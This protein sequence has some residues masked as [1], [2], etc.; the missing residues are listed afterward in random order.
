MGLTAIE[1]IATISLNLL[2]CART[3]H[4]LPCNTT[5]M[6][7]CTGNNEICK[8]NK[9]ECDDDFARYY[10]ECVPQEAATTAR[11][12]VTA[13]I[14]SIFTISI[15]I[16]GLVVVIRK[17]N[18]IEYIRQKIELRRSH[19]IMYEDVMIGHD[20]PPLSP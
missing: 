6:G 17:Y 20:D 13:A 18:L 19:N 1:I 14:I 9:C 3:E 5:L 11:Y 8:E 4:I 12:D 7:Q 2:Q 16:V 15:V 10:D